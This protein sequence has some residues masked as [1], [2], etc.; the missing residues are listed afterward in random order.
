MIFFQGVQIA[1]GTYTELMRTCP[2]FMQWTEV[3]TRKL[4]SDSTATNHSS[5]Q[6]DPA[7]VSEYLTQYSVCLLK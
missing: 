3:T 1:T 6:L 4:R 7:P 5:S 2:A